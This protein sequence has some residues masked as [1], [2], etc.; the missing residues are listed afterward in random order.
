[1]Q[2]L[3]VKYSAKKNNLK[4]SGDTMETLM[5]MFVI[6][7]ILAGLIIISYFSNSVTES[8]ETRV[9]MKE[10]SKIIY[11]SFSLL[12]SIGLLIT[13]HLSKNIFLQFIAIIQL[14]TG[15][16]EIVRSVNKLLFPQ[17]TKEK[18]IISSH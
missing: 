15:P 12:M 8:G 1:L 13:A 7:P 4:K 14:T 6:L 17:K 5:F 10:I 9:K 18:I 3:L 16:L 11:I 2:P